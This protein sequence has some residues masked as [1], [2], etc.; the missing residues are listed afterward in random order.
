MRISGRHTA[1][2]P[3]FVLSF[4]LGSFNSLGVYTSRAPPSLTLA[5]GLSAATL[6]LSFI[7]TGLVL[8]AKLVSPRALSF[9]ASLLLFTSAVLLPAALLPSAAALGAAYGILQV[10]SL[11]LTHAWFPDAVAGAT[12][13]LTGLSGLGTLVFVA[14]NTV[15]IRA[16]PVIPALRVA[17]LAASLI[18]ALAAARVTEPGDQC[19][20]SDRSVLARD[21]E[22]GLEPT[23]A[24]FFAA[25]PNAQAQPLL[26][27]SHRTAILADI[28]FFS[29]DVTIDN[30][31]E[32]ASPHSTIQ[33]SAS[34]LTSPLPSTQFA[35]LPLPPTLSL[36]PSQPRKALRD[37]FSL[38]VAALLVAVFGAFGPGFGAALHA[39]RMQ[40]HLLATSASVAELRFFGMILAGVVARVAS[41]WAVEALAAFATRRAFFDEGPDAFSAA[42][43]VLG[44]ALAAQ[45]VGG[46]ALPVLAR[47]GF[48]P[49]FV[50][51]LTGVYCTFFATAVVVPVLA[52]GFWGSENSALVL[53]MSGVAMGVSNATFSAVVGSC[54][55]DAYFAAVAA[56]SVAGCLGCV[57]MGRDC[58]GV[59][60]KADDWVRRSE[61]FDSAFGSSAPPSSARA[62][63]G[64]CGESAELIFDHVDGK[65]VEEFNPLDAHA[66]E[67]APRSTRRRD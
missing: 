9:L 21:E 14:A 51:V 5:L 12:A 18:V 29:S 50:V 25:E 8:H 61:S 62:G 27:K 32:P 44:A 58:G 53:A 15:L 4:A 30:D 55:Y 40:E 67:I 17:T 42:R 1:V 19:S 22:A 57:A 38:R 37:V 39:V 49:G 47:V 36:A 60:A 52:R 35:R 11:H 64:G 59:E 7:L 65:G 43:I 31:T 34:P 20:T 6:S 56:V 23:T 66:S 10:A 41:G 26:S 45:A 3:A 63:Y 46:A 13:A 24:P 54:G 2:L 48:A 33:Y 28:A 16:L